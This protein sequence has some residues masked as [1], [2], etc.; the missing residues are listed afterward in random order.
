MIS[1]ALER[2]APLRTRFRSASR[3]ARIRSKHC[4]RSWRFQSSPTSRF[5]T[6]RVA[7]VLLELGWDSIDIVK[8]DDFVDYSSTN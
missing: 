1:R 8:K 7:L 2:A 4:A 3:C 5:F 6:L